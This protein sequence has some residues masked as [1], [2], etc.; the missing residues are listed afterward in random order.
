MNRHRAFSNRAFTLI[1]LLVVIAI[2]A[3]LASLLLPSMS[4][5]KMKAQQTACLN[6][7][8]QL[9]MGWMMYI[10]DHGNVMPLNDNLKTSFSPNTSTTNAWVS[11]D[12]TVSADLSYIKQG[13]I[14][15][16]TGNPGVYH[17]P[18]DD[19][20]I[21]QSNVLR[22][23]SYSLDYYLN[24]SIDPQYSDYLPADA[25]STVVV[26]YSGISLPASTFAF[27]D[28]NANT[29]EDGV[30]LLFR[31]PDETWQNAPS[32]RHNQGANFSFTDGHCEHWKWRAPKQMLELGE[33]VSGNDDLLDLRRL[34]AALPNAP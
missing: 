18:S 14:Y 28:E 7:L 32:D 8:R 1:E 3:I 24:G 33:G 12:A 6:N 2:I 30:Y 27:L 16:Y 4:R 11:G 29:I 22:T 26:K 34:Q 25:A 31:A 21:T 5:A 15:P 13:T 10:D 20:L 19:S 17:C 23:R 9:Q